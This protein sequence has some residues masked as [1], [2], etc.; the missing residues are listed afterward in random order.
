MTLYLL[1][2]NNY[3]NRIYKRETSVLDYIPY[4]IDNTPAN[5]PMTYV[6][7]IP[8]DGLLTEQDIDITTEFPDYVI[9]VDDDNQIVSRWFVIETRRN[10][11]GQYKAALRRDLI[12]DYWENIASAPMFIEKGYCSV[13][14]NFIFNDEQ[15][16]V[17]QIKNREELLKDKTDCAWIV[18]YCAPTDSEVQTDIDV[19]YGVNTGYDFYAPTLED[20]D[21]YSYLNKSYSFL[22]D[23][24]FGFA[25]RLNSELPVEDS[26]VFLYNFTK[27]GLVS[28]EKFDYTGKTIDMMGTVQIRPDQV[29]GFSRQIAEAINS[30][31][32]P[33]SMY[34]TML[35]NYGI[36]ANEDLRLTL[37]NLE[38][39][40]VKIGEK[41]YGISLNTD[42]N[43]AGMVITEHDSELITAFNSAY[44]QTWYT[45]LSNISPLVTTP[46]NNLISLNNWTLRKESYRTTYTTATA[47]LTL[48]EIDAV[49]GL[50]F[51]FPKDRKPLSD[52]PYCM[53]CMPYVDDM[54]IGWTDGGN[55][56]IETSA[57]NA[58]SV[59]A[60][61]AT[62]L[63]ANL[64]DIQLL[65]Y[66][67]IGAIREN[68]INKTLDLRVEPFVNWQKNFDFIPVEGA[69]TMIFFATT[70]KDSF[71]IKVG[72][73]YVYND[74]LTFKTNMLT[75]TVRLCSPN[76]NGLFEFSPYKNRGFS[77][78]KVDYHY[79]PFQPYIH[80]SPNFGGLYGADYGDA[81]GL[82][83]GG[84]FS[85]PITSD[86][87]INYQIQNKNFQDQFNRE[88]E[89]M[90]LKQKYGR[91]QELWSIVSGTISGTVSGAATGMM[92]TGNPYAAAAG[93]VV[94]G[95]ASLA[96]GIRDLQINDA[97][98]NE[99]LDYTK[100]MFGMR[101]D[102]IKAL[103]N[104]LTRVSS[105]NNNNKIFP[106]IE[107]YTCS[108]EEYRA[109][110][111][112]LVYNGFTI[113]RIDTL[114]NNINN[115]PLY[116]GEPGYFKG[117][118]IRLQDF[119]EDSHLANAIAGELYKGVYI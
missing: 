36:S 86:A 106:F 113:G 48:T 21:F 39:K 47:T 40:V 109:V 60:G 83:C 45:F 64:Y 91:E 69:D 14:D 68:V 15:V 44:A 5:N 59:A 85:L 101:I 117:Q 93:A 52:S 49:S 41:R 23:Y 82:I 34:S 115:K 24:N 73:Y 50:S 57:E 53:F 42:P 70:S 107:L 20:W 38:G 55:K 114:E 22:E 28:M 105:I 89:S 25:V 88:I 4:M 92:A 6:N 80:V 17:N 110:S 26:P 78:V 11:A 62:S 72:N 43:R 16:A 103:P 100:D 56:F 116:L 58:M 9:Y 99:A 32:V 90:E 19:V 35:T 37:E 3:Y 31:T 33:A 30:N 71:N 111:R 18:G 10:S 112:K 65:P 8:G 2:Y 27:S 94:G 77:N 95:V 84:D 67:P 51:K 7:L 118:L 61:L 119:N 74:A 108:D 12:A 97:L 87:W 13:E 81:R 46:T 54:I 29:E 79:K 1:Q 75:Q 66:C 102:N 104:S 96:G 76:Y 98:R 63:G